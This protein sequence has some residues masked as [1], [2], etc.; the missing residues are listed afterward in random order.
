[1]LCVHI[2]GNELGIVAHDFRQNGFAILVNRCHLNEINN[3]PPRT[4]NR[5]LCLA[6][7]CSSRRRSQR[8]R[9]SIDKLCLRSGRREPTLQEL[10][11]GGAP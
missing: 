3:A 9:T 2:A 8:Q 6:L 4:H 1:M 5:Q 10:W 11:G 7:C